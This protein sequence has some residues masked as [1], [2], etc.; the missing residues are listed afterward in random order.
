MW[1]SFAGDLTQALRDAAWKY[2]SATSG[3]EIQAPRWQSCLSK[4][5]NAFGFAAAHEYV[6]TNFEESAKADVRNSYC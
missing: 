5:V 6:L 2:Q 3:I 4:S 1:M